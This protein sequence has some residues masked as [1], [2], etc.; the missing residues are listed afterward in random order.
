MVTIFVET[1]HDGDQQVIRSRPLFSTWMRDHEIWR[2]RIFNGISNSLWWMLAVQQK[3]CRFEDGHQWKVAPEMLTPGI[4]FA[5]RLLHCFER[6]RITKTL[7]ETFWAF[8]ASDDFL[9]CWLKLLWELCSCCTA[10]TC[11]SLLCAPHACCSE[12]DTLFPLRTDETLS[13]HIPF[14]NSLCHQILFIQYSLD[15]NIKS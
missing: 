14:I 6:M 8:V 10:K 9:Q 13:Y 5:G 7:V 12:M 4:L 2:W 15:N 11:W 3:K 1:W